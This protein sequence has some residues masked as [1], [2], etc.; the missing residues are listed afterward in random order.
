MSIVLSIICAGVALFFGSAFW[1]VISSPRC[2]RRLLCDPEEQ[3]R[4]LK[5]Y[6]PDLTK[7]AATVEPRFLGSY[8]GNIEQSKSAKQKRTRLD[9]T[10]PLQQAPRGATR[11]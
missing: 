2:F 1:T 3:T 7:R 8:A 9:L 4:I 10:F 6:G 5:H 11:K